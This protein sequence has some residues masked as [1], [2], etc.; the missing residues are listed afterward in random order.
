L[1]AD[2][3]D[4]WR[5]RLESTGGNRNHPQ[6][7]SGHVSD[8]KGRKVLVTGAG[9]FI[10][11]HL[12]EELV[13]RGADVRAFVRY[14]ARGDRG[15]LRLVPAELAERID[16]RFGDVTDPWRVDEAVWGVD[17]VFHLAAL[18]AIPY[19]YVAPASYVET[20]VSGTLNVLQAVRRHG[21]SRMVHT[22]TS[23]CYGTA[24]YTPIDEDHP[25]QA[26]SPYSASKIGADKIAESFRRSFGT[27]VAT[28][29][30][31]NTFGPR[32][33]ARA[34]I[35]T[36]IAQALA[37]LPELKLG[38]LDPVRDLNPVLD[39]VEGFLAVASSDDCLGVVTNVGAGKGIAIGDLAKRIL[40][41]CG[42]D[43]MPIVTDFAR[44][45]VEK[46]EVFKLVCANARAKERCGWEPRRTLDDGLRE[47]I[48][49]VR[50]HPD[51]YRPDEYA[52]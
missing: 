36:I 12:A 23:E 39:T 45:R 10:G 49:F 30:P 33:S 48:E 44:V 14:N 41:L 16:V 28:I 20:N 18:I 35:P 8:W 34:V 22:S 46:S 2:L 3:L 38:S 52:V 25:L 9:G 19:S 13:R 11:S 40:A 27:P 29:R 42:R 51:L 31:F 32:Q 26:Q 47:T 7:G 43:D 50:A 1:L 37:G 17:V 15:L 21:V 6:L 5:A 24:L 4:G